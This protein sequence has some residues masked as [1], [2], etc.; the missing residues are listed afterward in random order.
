MLPKITELE[1]NTEELTEDLP[2][3]GKSFLFDF[4]KNEFVMRDGKLVELYGI[5]SLKMWIE[6]M[7]RTER[8]RFEVYEGTEYG[9]LLEDLI[10][11]NYPRTFVEAEIKRE[12]TETLLT[13]P[14]IN[15][16]ENWSFER[17][18]KWMRI[19]L[20]VVT[21]DTEFAQEVMM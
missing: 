5:D 21:S 15:A 10:G 2:P 19:N 11:S 3:I 4:N 16:V 13:H 6:K 17:D 7:M 12:V 9:I 18:G 14:H 1:F 20:T 8:Y